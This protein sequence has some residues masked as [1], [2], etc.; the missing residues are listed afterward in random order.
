[1]DVS[2]VFENT[3]I[4]IIPREASKASGIDYRTPVRYLADDGVLLLIRQDTEQAPCLCPDC[5]AQLFTEG[6][7]E[8]END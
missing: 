2:K 8:N 5:F 4:I 7:G 3:S 1:M 6:G